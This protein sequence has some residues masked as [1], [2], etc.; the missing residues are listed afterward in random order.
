MTQIQ[1]QTQ[2]ESQ[3]LL[4]PP[5]GVIQEVLSSKD[6]SISWLAGDGSDRCYYRIEDKDHNQSYVLMKLSQSDASLL[7]EGK[8]EWVILSYLLTNYGIRVPRAIKL[9]PEY[10]SLIIEDYGDVMLETYIDKYYTEDYS[11]VEEIFSQATLICSRML[12]ISY[13]GSLWCQRKFDSSRFIWEL[14]FFLTHYYND[15]LSLFLSTSE[16]TLFDKEAKELSDF[17]TGDSSYFVHRDFHSRNIMLKDGTLA[18]IDFQD[19]RLGPCSYDLVSLIYDNYTP[20]TMEERNSIFITS[21]KLIKESV[22]DKVYQRILSEYKY[23]LLQ[24]QLKAIGSY[25]YLTKKKQK[26]DYLRY[27]PKALESILA[28]LK[29][30]DRFSFLSKTLVSR[31]KEKIG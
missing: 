28:V 29:D 13:D 30:D 9:I 26:R 4:P 18:V 31:M 21:S 11:K 23:V 10:A 14:N 7:K 5:I 1:T 20:L 6:L 22:S 3:I 12:S 25:G 15:T 24:R 2:S 16:K 27:V 19:S 17:I 8:Y